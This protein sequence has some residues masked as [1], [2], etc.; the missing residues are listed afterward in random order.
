MKNSHASTVPVE[1][2][3]TLTVGVSLVPHYAELRYGEQQW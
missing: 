1:K 3:V 2:R